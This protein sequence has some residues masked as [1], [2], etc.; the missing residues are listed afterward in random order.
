MIA[1]PLFNPS[2]AATPLK[3]E[4]A[5]HRLII[6]YAAKGYKYRE[7]A[8]L[9]GVT[10]TTVRNTVAQPFAQEHLVNTIQQSV[11]EEAREMLSREVIPSL[12]LLVSVRDNP[13][14]RPADRLSAANSTL[15]RFLGKASQ[16]ITVTE[17]PISELTDEELRARA[18]SILTRFGN[19]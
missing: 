9:T 13:N 3:H 7:I 6:D 2:L 14:A 12:K 16:P 18:N 11:Q 1:R 4:R 8:T 5:L 17:K 15:D 19:S 10:P